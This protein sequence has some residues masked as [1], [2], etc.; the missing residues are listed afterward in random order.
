MLERLNIGCIG[1]SIFNV[2]FEVFLEFHVLF[3]VAKVEDIGEGLKFDGII[4]RRTLLMEGHITSVGIFAIL[5]VLVHC[6]KLCTEIVIVEE[7]WG[8]CFEQGAG[9]I[10]G[11][12]SEAGNNV[13][14]LDMVVVEGLR[15]HA[16]EEVTMS[17]KGIIF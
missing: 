6:V 10:G 8:I 17:N 1:K 13:C 15:P 11:A 5:G 16:K 4:K 2:T 7:E 3:F 14:N 12:G 9:P